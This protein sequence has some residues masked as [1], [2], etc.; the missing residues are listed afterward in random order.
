M[1]S[2]VPLFGVDKALI[3][4]CTLPGLPGRPRHDGPGG[5]DRVYDAVAPDLEMLQRAG[6]DGLLFVNEHDTPYSQV[7]GIE[8]ATA[9]AAVVGRLRA[10]ISLPF[11]ID[12]LWDAKATLAVARATGAGFVRGIFTGAFDGDVGLVARDW[13]E[14]AGYRHMIAADNVA[15]F[16][17]ITPEYAGAIAGRPIPDRA[18]SAAAQDIDGLLVSGGYIGL[19][20]DVALMRSIKEAAP[21]TALIATSGV[22]PETAE[23]VLSVADGAIVGSAMRQAG[24][25][26]NPVDFDRARRMSEIFAAAR[27][28][29]ARVR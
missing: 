28:Q 1:K 11:G 18:R 7:V 19:A 13:G 21:E 20:P 10:N 16:T 23:R 14:L 6:A 25:V 9:M 26:W 3:A 8:A 4:A 17:N 22:V 12:L 29:G 5:M 24:S 15:V 2:L 27:G